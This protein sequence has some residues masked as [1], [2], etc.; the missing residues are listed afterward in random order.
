[1][2]FDLKFCAWK[3]KLYRFFFFLNFSF[4]EYEWI[5]VVVAWYYNSQRSL[6]KEFGSF[7]KFPILKREMLQDFSIS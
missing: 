1:M 7:I 4:T 3:V 2:P 5:Y 6:E